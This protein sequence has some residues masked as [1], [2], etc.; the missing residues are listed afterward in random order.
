M[1]TRAD[2]G[3]FRADFPAGESIIRELSGRVNAKAPLGV[4]EVATRARV[5]G[6]PAQGHA[7]ATVNGRSHVISWSREDLGT[8]A[9]D[10]D[11]A[12]A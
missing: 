2:S 12:A 9:R 8:A 10:L 7:G 4:T 5:A 6:G 3:P 11:V 1:T